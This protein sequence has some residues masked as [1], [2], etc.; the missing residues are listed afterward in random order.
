MP[1]AFKP[2]SRH[3]VVP[4]PP[5]PR[6]MVNRRLAHG[7][8]IRLWSS[9]F[10]HAAGDPTAHTT[11]EIGWVEQ[12]QARY[13]FGARSCDLPAEAVMIVPPGVE[14]TTSLANFRGGALHVDAG[15][16]E[17]VTRD[18]GPTAHG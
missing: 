18:L 4:V 16:L 2:T 17:T 15:I 11:R 6:L 7:I 8:T 12:G 14:H 5:G 9:P 13:D 3:P 10:A 1:S